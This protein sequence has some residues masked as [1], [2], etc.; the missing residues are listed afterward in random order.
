VKGEFG[1]F[2]EVLDKVK[3][4]LD[5]AGRHIEAT[6]VRTRA[7]KRKLRDV[8]SLAGDEATRLL[9]DAAGEDE[10]APDETP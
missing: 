1:K 9:G 8:E 4:K 10:P 2:G 5:E 6:G 7:I 3:K